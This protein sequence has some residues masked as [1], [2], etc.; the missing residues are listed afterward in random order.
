[1]SFVCGGC[2]EEIIDVYIE[3]FEMY[4]HPYH[5]ACKICGKDFSDGSKVEEGPDGF[6]YCSQDFNEVFAPK[7]H[8]CGEIIIGEVISAGQLQFHPHHFGESCACVV[9]TVCAVR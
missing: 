6:A 5:L 3:A 4:W 8:N 9:C 7:C 2:N 1:M